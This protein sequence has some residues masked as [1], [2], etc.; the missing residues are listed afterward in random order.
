M[1]HELPSSIRVSEQAKD[2]LIK[3]KRITGIKQ[4]NVLCRWA[5]CVSL[6]D[7]TPPLVR[8]IKADSNVEMTWRT[9]SGPTDGALVALLR[10][11]MSS[12]QEGFESLSDLTNAHLHRGIGHLAGTLR[13]SD[14][15]M[16]LIALGVADEH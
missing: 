3:L 15:I 16:G 2:Q 11:R 13:P 9:F 14:G 12:T 8:A 7:P 5:I 10:K 1:S 4:W 6:A